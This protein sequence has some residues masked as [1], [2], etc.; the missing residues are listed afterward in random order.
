MKINFSQIRA[1]GSVEKTAI[2]K[3]A[4]RPVQIVAEPHTKLEISIEADANDQKLSSDKTKITRQGN[5]MLISLA[6]EVLVQVIDFYDADDVV[7]MGVEWNFSAASAVGAET[8]DAL[9]LAHGGAATEE[10]AS[11]LGGVGVWGLAFGGLA[12]AGG[13]GGGGGA[14]DPLSA[15]KS[16][17]DSNHASAITTNLSDYQAAG[18][19]GVNSS[20]LAAINSILKDADITSATV[21]TTAKLQTLVN[22]YNAILAAADGTAGNG[23]APSATDY[24]NVGVNGIA[25]T[26]EVSLLGSAIDAKSSADVD[27]AAELQ[28]LADAVQAVMTTAAGGTP[29][30][31][32]AQ[33]ALLGITGVTTNNIADIVTAI[34]GTT[35]DG[36][37]VS[38]LTALQTLANN[39]NDAPI[40]T[41]PGAL[42]V[43]EDT[44]LV[45]TGLSV[46]D[47]DIAATEMLSVT[48]SVGHGAITVAAATGVTQ[49]GTATAQT[50]TGTLADINAALAVSNAV[51]YRGNSDYNGSDTLT[52]TSND[53]GHTGTDGVKTDVDTVA[54]TVTPIPDI[55]SI[56]LSATGAQNSTLNA[57][58]VVTVTVTFDQAITVTGTPQLALNIGGTL[59][60]ANYT[61]GTGTTSLTF[62][63]TI[64]SGNTDGNGIS[65]DA[66]AFSTNGGTLMNA[67]GAAAILTHAAV[68]DDTRFLVDAI[69]PSEPVVTLNTDTALTTDFQTSNGQLDVSRLEV[70]ATWE[71]SL[72]R[73][74]TWHAGNGGNPVAVTT[75]TFVAPAGNY[76]AGDVRVRQTDAAGQISGEGVL[77]HPSSLAGVDGAFW[78]AYPDVLAL[79][80]GGYVVA[81]YGQTASGLTSDIFIQRYDSASVAVGSAHQ[82]SG[83]SG[84]GRDADPQLAAFAD[85]SYVVTW[86]GDTTDGQNY[87]LFVQR[88]DNTD[89]AVGST[90][91]LSGVSGNYT[92]WTP[93]VVTL[94]DGGYVVTWD[95]V[96]TDGKDDIFVQRFDSAG[97]LVGSVITLGGMNGNWDNMPQVA[98]LSD[99]GY[100]VAWYNVSPQGVYESMLQ[101]Y[102]SAN[103]P[104]GS[105]ISLA[106]GYNP[107]V[108]A[109]NDGGYIVAWQGEAA[110]GYDE[111]FVQRYDSAN[112]T[113]GS[114][115]QLHGTAGDLHDFNVSVARMNDGGYVVTWQGETSDGQNDDIFVQRFDS[116][117]AAVGSIQRLAG[118]G[119]VWLDDQPQVTALDSGGYVVTWNSGTSDNGYDVFVQLFNSANMAV[120]GV[121][122]LSGTPGAYDDYAISVAGLRDGGYVI[123]WNGQTSIG[124]D[125]DI[126][127]R[128]F[129][130]NGDV[131][132][133]PLVID[134]T[135]PTV[136]SMFISGATGMGNGTLAVG[137]VVSVTVTMS[138]DTVVTGTPKLSLNLGGVVVQASY[139]S[140]SG[141]SA[142]I[143]TY[144]I[145][146]GLND[147]NGISIVADSLTLNGGRLE[148]ATGHDPLAAILTHA[149]VVDNAS[150]L[151][152]TSTPLIL[153]L[154][155]DGTHTVGQSAGVVFD[156]AADGTANRTGWVDRYDGLLALDLNHNGKIDNG[157]E[158][159]GSGTSLADGS[160]AKDG[161]AALR[162]YDVNSDGVIDAKDA[163]F[164]NL[165]VWVDANTDGIT[166]AGELKGLSELG[167]ASF[168]LNALHAV[169]T[170]NGNH[171]I[172]Q[173]SWTDTHG[174][175]H[176]LADWTFTNDAR[177]VVVANDSVILG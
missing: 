19:T 88:Y 38:S 91:R 170:E 26:T 39:V 115:Q 89:V 163:V 120:G 125:F 97:G 124:H 136:S 126:F 150:Y 3:Q 21:N 57:G 46:A 159:L 171:V 73:G 66:N 96:N 129:D 152:D 79:P 23:T 162:Q 154:N 37:G 8:T 76:V 59:V 12:I 72:D 93:Q 49:S 155:G 33:L 127:M 135:G 151:V 164:A 74:V 45:I 168:N 172:L 40:N 100:V 108:T 145:E 81:W 158:L 54:I 11:L 30:V 53:A 106:A 41:V 75:D 15:I 92:A 86:V 122:R 25:T 60:Q 161:F 61:S 55:T 112:A 63:Y 156:V 153:D 16:T 176:S 144:A 9:A 20:N 4:G 7:L 2:T 51:V 173:S 29:A 123:T 174:V 103:A 139:V 99:G 160:K 140:D 118:T 77:S 141:T 80:D 67:A 109:M 13:G 132:S 68:T 105:T 58:D 157:G 52:V 69:A 31:T 1:N 133:L 65:V 148:D 48:L 149:A 90:T 116:A 36:S 14:S 95:E 71:Y 169:G 50:L 137:D 35:D 146:A 94:L 102:D 147:A 110:N 98:A 165:N 128:R 111:V 62:S 83:M 119:G 142:L 87:D 121:Q 10:S 70:G 64:E 113:V 104:V 34:V 84:N 117:N 175:A 143:F 101:R 56:V 18:V 47:A 78:D 32:Q 5:D 138:E 22:S 167:I 85:G 43:N 28:A 130:A 24:T 6:G 177:P 131:V 107:L 166:D 82:L 27:T 114:L 44:D 134:A 17:A 42:T